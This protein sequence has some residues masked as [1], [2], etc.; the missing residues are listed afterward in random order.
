MC[1]TTSAVISTANELRAEAQCEVSFPVVRGKVLIW[2]HYLMCLSE[3]SAPGR[4]EA[5][6]VSFGNGVW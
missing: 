4:N 2:S 5:R 1:S 3:G 6:S